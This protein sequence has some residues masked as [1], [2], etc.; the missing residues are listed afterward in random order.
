MV[1][2]ARLASEHVAD[3]E[4]MKTSA[5]QEAAYYRAKLTAFENANEP[6]V[7]RLERERVADLER[8]MSTLMNERWEQDRTLSEISDSLALHT[9]LYEQAEARAADANKRAELIEESHER[10]L[11]RH[12]NIQ[13]RHNHMEVQLRDHA[14]R[15]LSQTSAL[16][17]KEADE[18]SLRAQVEELIQS[19]DQHLRA[20]EQAGIALQAASSRREEIDLQYDRAREQISTLEVDVVELRGELES[21]TAEVESMRTRLTDVENSWA[22]SREEADAFRA[23]TTGGLGELLDSHRDLKTDEDRMARGH[24]EKQHA[25]ESEAASLRKMLKE[26]TQHADQSQTQLAEERRRVREH[27]TEQSLLRSQIV[28]LR[29]QLSSAMVDVGH[30]KKELIDR[31]ARLGEKAKEASDATVRLGMLRNYLAENGIGV[32]EDDRSRSRAQGGA[33]SAVVAELE[34]KLAER[35]RLHE[36]A[37]REL[38]Q[39]LRRRRDVES[40]LTQVSTQLEKVRSSPSIAPNPEAE[41]R[42]AEAER[43]LEETEQG[44][45]ARMQQ[46]EEDYQ[47]AVHYVKYVAFHILCSIHL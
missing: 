19:R 20:L 40:Q 44:Y 14:D 33:S 41:A 36:N 17:Q 34:S 32:D 5:T 3:A 23:L 4:R 18:M 10:T 46:M 45:K 29:A 24:A 12:G 28:G 25:V 16:E 30:F 11:Q 21:R 47:L 13:E 37:E 6:E 22:K 27:E 2:Q 35:T 7:A 38:A 43:K 31:D 26:A 15:L 42:A 1:E 9:T 39:A 8:H